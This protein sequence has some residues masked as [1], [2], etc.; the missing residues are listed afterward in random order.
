MLTESLSCQ[1]NLALELSWLLKVPSHRCSPQT[2]ETLT[3]DQVHPLIQGI[4]LG[5]SGPQLLHAGLKEIL[6]RFLFSDAGLFLT[7][8]DSPAPDGQY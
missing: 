6:P 4:I 2:W 8:A 5:P 7:I 3:H 1:V